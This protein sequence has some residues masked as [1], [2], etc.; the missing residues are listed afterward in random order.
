MNPGVASI[1]NEQFHRAPGKIKPN[2]LIY[3]QVLLW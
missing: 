3:K 2:T 1:I